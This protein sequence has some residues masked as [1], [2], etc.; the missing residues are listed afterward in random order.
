MSQVSLDQI[1]S[2]V[3]SP[4]K[5]VAKV[6]TVG[7]CDLCR[8]RSGRHPLRTKAS[9]GVGPFEPMPHR[10]EHDVNLSRILSKIT[11][12]DAGRHDIQVKVGWRW[13]TSFVS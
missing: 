5:I 6:E 8:D 12:H 2:D 10:T 13:S 1:E 3:L 11:R 4:P 7:T 9:A